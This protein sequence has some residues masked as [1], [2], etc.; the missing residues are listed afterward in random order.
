[1]TR[2]VATQCLKRREPPITCLALKHTVV[3]SVQVGGGSRK[4]HQVVG[5]GY[6]INFSFSLHHY[7]ISIVLEIILVFWFEG[8]IENGYDQGFKKNRKVWNGLT[9]V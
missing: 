2:T 6:T 9:G 5:H 8:V 1:M 7:I 4:Q 3:G